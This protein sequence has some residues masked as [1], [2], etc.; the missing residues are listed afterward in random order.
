MIPVASTTPARHSGANH[1]RQRGSD[2]TTGD[3]VA[4]AAVAASVGGA[5]STEPGNGGPC[6]DSGRRIGRMMRSPHRATSRPPGTGRPRTSTGKAGPAIGSPPVVRAS[7]VQTGRVPA[8]PSR[9]KGGSG[10]G[11]DPT[12]RV[13]HGDHRERR[14]TRG[15]ESIGAADR[16][17]PGDRRGCGHTDREQGQQDDLAHRVAVTGDDDGVGVRRVDRDGLIGLPGSG[18][19]GS[20]DDDDVDRDGLAGPGMAVLD[21]DLVTAGVVVRRHLADD[22]RPLVAVAAGGIDLPDLTEGDRCHR[23]RG[24]AQ[25]PPRPQTVAADA[26]WRRRSAPVRRRQRVVVGASVDGRR[27][28]RRRR[29]RRTEVE[30]RFGASRSTRRSHS[31]NPT[32]C[33]AENPDANGGHREGDDDDPTARHVVQCIDDADHQSARVAANTSGA[34]ITDERS[35]AIT[36]STV[37]TMAKDATSSISNECSGQT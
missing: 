33:M 7:N 18:R 6:F 26:G 20:F 28:P 10:L 16:P 2:A 32:D 17:P 19:N 3:D 35:A 12:A 4:G 34:A 37:S 8:A 36:A 21:R 1:P 13:Q 5:P 25:P 27:G 14:L 29:Q 23:Q 24:Q 30:R 11:R 9:D 31:R 22:V 15:D